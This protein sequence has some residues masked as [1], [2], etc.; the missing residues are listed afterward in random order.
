MEL[1]VE[2]KNLLEAKRRL[3][4]LKTPKNK[5]L[6]TNVV[7]KAENNQLLIA[8]PGYAISVRSNLPHHTTS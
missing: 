4:A 6:A 3:L 1:I 8:L 7:L 5:K 2:K